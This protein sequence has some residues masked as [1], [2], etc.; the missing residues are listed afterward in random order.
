MRCRNSLCV[1]PV[2]T[3]ADLA[4]AVSPTT[5]LRN[6][7]HL[8]VESATVVFFFTQVIHVPAIHALHLT[9]GQIRSGMGACAGAVCCCM[10]FPPA[11]Q[12]PPS[13]HPPDRC[14]AHPHLLEMLINLLQPRGTWLAKLASS[15]PEAPSLRES[16][17]QD[18]RQENEPH[19]HTAT[20]N[21][22]GL[23]R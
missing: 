4:F 7:T 18:Q 1:K 16:G 20:A 17:E 8:L 19:V 2:N 22:H 12:G 21:A 10:H 5:A 11:C 14:L 6:I 23:C 3:F 15:T 9:E 13:S